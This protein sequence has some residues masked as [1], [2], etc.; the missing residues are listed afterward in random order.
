MKTVG[1]FV[2][3]GSVLVLV[4]ACA[5]LDLARAGYDVAQQINC[6]QSE[7]RGACNRDWGDDYSAWQ[8]QRSTYLKAL[9]E[10]KEAAKAG[11]GWLQPV[12]LSD[13]PDL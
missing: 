11:A 7:P 12:D 2:A 6:E 13:L 5:N 3:T 8:A 9:E 1:T 10:E 4:S